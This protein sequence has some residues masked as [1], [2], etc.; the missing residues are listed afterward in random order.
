MKIRYWIKI[1]VKY[2][3]EMSIMPKEMYKSTMLK[4][5]QCEKYPKVH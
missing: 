4:E 3:L 5:R 2:R 1:T